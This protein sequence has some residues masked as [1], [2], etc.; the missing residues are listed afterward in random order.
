MNSPEIILKD[1]WRL[2]SRFRYVPFADLDL[3]DQELVRSGSIYRL[4]GHAR[5]D[6]W[7]YPVRKDGGL[8]RQAR[9]VRLND[10][11]R[12]HRKIRFLEPAAA[13]RYLQRVKTG[14]WESWNYSGKRELKMSKGYGQV[15]L[16]PALRRRLLAAFDAERSHATELGIAWIPPGAYDKSHFHD[17][18][19]IVLALSKR[20]DTGKLEFKRD[21]RW[22]EVEYDVGQA[23][24]I[25]KYVEHRVMP[26]NI[27]RYT[28]AISILD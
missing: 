19:V 24:L 8:T 4:F 18:D 1:G 3:D 21:G 16:L 14:P 17:V 15:E 2:A 9:R 27:D 22:G 28:A 7:L 26:T 6:C 13:N 10:R 23:V 20:N 5:E 11:D 25:P 12:P